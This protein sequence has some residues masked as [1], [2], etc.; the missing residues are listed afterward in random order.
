[1]KKIKIQ[2]VVGLRRKMFHMKHYH[3]PFMNTRKTIVLK[4]LYSE[5]LYCRIG[6]YNQSTFFPAWPRPGKAAGSGAVL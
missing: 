1:M 5:I 4:T 2:D 6:S 3:F